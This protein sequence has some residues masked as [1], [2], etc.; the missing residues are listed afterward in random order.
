MRI[1]VVLILVAALCG[2]CRVV[3]SYHRMMMLR[4]ARALS[5]EYTACVEV[6]RTNPE[7]IATLCKPYLDGLKAMNKPNAARPQ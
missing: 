7:M 3:Q 1:T 4:Q 6:N 2:S 5:T